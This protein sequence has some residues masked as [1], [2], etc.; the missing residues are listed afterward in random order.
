MVLF[1]IFSPP[2]FREIMNFTMM[3][4]KSIR[5]PIVIATYQTNQSHNNSDFSRHEKEFGVIANFLAVCC[6]VAA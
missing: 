5:I 3:N 6:S 1:S 2:I 4:E